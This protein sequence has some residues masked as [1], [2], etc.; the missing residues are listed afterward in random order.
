[1]IAATVAVLGLGP[2]GRAL[3]FRLAR[4]GVDTVAVDAAPDRVWRPTYAAWA[5]ELPSWL[6]ATAIST[7]TR[8]AAFARSEHHLSRHYV[9]LD[10]AGL[11]RSLDLGGVRA[12]RGR[13]E[14]ADAHD[15]TLV[16]G[17]TLRAELVVDARGSRVQPTKVQQTAYGL[18]VSRSQAEPIGP[19]WF[20]D[21][22]TDHGAGETAPPSFLYAVPL[23]DEHVLL[24]E[25]C[26]VGRPALGAPELRDRLRARLSA[27]GVRLTG[28]ERVEHVRFAVEPEPVSRAPRR[29]GPRTEPLRFGA[30]GGLMHPATG[31]SVASSLVAAERLAEAV[32]SEGTRIAA[33]EEVLWSRPARQVRALRRTGLTTLL[34]LPPD[35]VPDFFEAFFALPP[36]L[37][38]GY[39]S[40]PDRPLVTLA[41]MASMAARL[42]PRLSAIAVTSAFGPPTGRSG[43]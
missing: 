38:R 39:L 10:T 29:G 7:S 28:E 25:T 18:V 35:R 5:D 26:L 36:S 2:A 24:E 14:S 15:V 43:S 37:Q 21:W 12:V 27:R 41:A 16:G 22:R 6:A 33:L 4:H 34:R 11:Q 3:A 19:T 32:A 1:V 23:D 42:P 30:R 13:V 8:P 20:M 17:E 31:Y 40:Q 9:V